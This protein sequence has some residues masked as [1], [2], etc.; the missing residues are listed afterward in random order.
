MM[1]NGIT[2]LYG[3]IGNPVAHTLSPLIHNTLAER[4]HHNMVYVPMQV[5]EGN[6]TDALKG[7]Y[8]LHVYGL[9]ITVPYKSEVLKSLVSVEELAG[10]IG[11][12]NTLVRTDGG[13]RG[14]NTDMT[15]LYR[16]MCTQGICMRGEH[17]IILGAGGAARA[18][19]FMCAYYGAAQVYLMNRTR[20]KAEIVAE[21]VNKVLTTDCVI[22]MAIEEYATL[23]KQQYLAIQAT[24]VGLYPQVEDVVIEDMDFY[25]KIHIGYDLI[26]R[27][28]QTRF[29]SLV[30]RAGGQAYSGLT[31]LLYQGIEAY[32]LWNQTKITEECAIDLYQVLQKE[33]E[34]NV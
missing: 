21:E 28:A 1:I 27:P 19:A 12:V 23:P 17:V 5:E 30:E 33:M 32:E 2:K 15:G 11:A 16:A 34:T 26:Y 14:Y 3:L 13:Y 22:P 31:M 9:N 18:V 4:L 24:S 6:L 29:L 8:A 20:E 25:D 7:A 10:K